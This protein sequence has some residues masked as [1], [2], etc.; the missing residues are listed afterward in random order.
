[1]SERLEHLAANWCAYVSIT[2]TSLP[3]NA[4][5]NININ[6]VYIMM[7]SRP[8]LCFSLKVCAEVCS[9]CKNTESGFSLHVFGMGTKRWG[10][11]AGALQ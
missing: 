1:M 3:I 11:K 5:G 9:R 8:V 10:R 7:I 4:P 2:N 6:V